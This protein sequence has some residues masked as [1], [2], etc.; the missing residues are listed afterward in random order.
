M[1]EQS[2]KTVEY[3][4]GEIVKYTRYD[5]DLIN[6]PNQKPTPD[7]YFK[8]Q[9]VD[10]DYGVV[11]YG[12]DTIGLAYITKTNFVDKVKYWLFW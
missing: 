6:E 11:D 7:K 10:M 5:D 12:E 9:K 3:K 1:I 8:V 4:I 2:L